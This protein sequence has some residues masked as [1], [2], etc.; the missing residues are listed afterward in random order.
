MEGNF[1]KK[2]YVVLVQWCGCVRYLVIS[3]GGGVR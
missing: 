2:G 3:G 1:F